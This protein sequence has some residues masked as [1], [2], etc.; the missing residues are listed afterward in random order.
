VQAINQRLPSNTS[1]SSCCHWGLHQPFSN[2]HSFAILKE[3]SPLLIAHPIY[4]FGFASKNTLRILNRVRRIIVCRTH[5]RVRKHVRI[6]R[7][8]IREHIA[9]EPGGYTPHLAST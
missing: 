6:A 7:S 1:K 2:R 9:Q 8:D 5:K 4:D 3:G